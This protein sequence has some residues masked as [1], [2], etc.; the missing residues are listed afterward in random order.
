M[1]RKAIAVVVLAAC[2]L[3][4]KAQFTSVNAQIVDSDGTQWANGTYTITFKGSVPG[5]PSINGIFFTQTFSGTLSATGQFSAT[6]ADVAYVYPPNSTWVFTVKAAT[7]S[8][9]IY[10]ISIP[11]TG[12][13]E[14]VSTQI[15]AA[16]KPPRLTGGQLSQAYND[17]EVTAVPGNIYFR[18][19]DGSF[20]CYTT[21]WVACGGISAITGTGTANTI[22]MWTGTTVL[23]N[24]PLSVISGVLTSSDPMAIISSSAPTQTD[25]TPSG[26][27]NTTTAGAASL[28]APT[29]VVTAGVYQLPSAPGSGAYTGTNAAGIVATTFT[30]FQGTDANLLTSGTFTGATGAAVCKD[31]NGGVTTVGCAAGGVTSLNS[32]SGVLSLTSTGATVTITP[33]GSTINLEVAAS[34]GF[35][36][37]IGSTSIAASS[38]TT[39]IAG[40]TLTSPTFTTPALGTPA[41]GVITNLTGTCA[42]CVAN[43]AGS[44]SNALTMNNSGTGAASGST[45]N[46]ASAQT[47][48]YNT[49]G[50]APLASPTFTGTV[51]VPS[52]SGLGTPTTLVLT[53]ATGLP[54]AT[55]ISGLGTGVATALAATPS[56]TGSIV[57]ATSPTLVTPNLGTPSALVLTS[58]TGLPW[59]SLVAP[60]AALSF[61]MPAG[62]TTSLTWAANAAPSSPNWTWTSGADTG[63]STAAAFSF[64]DTT[65]STKTGSL[66]NINTVG[67]STALPLQ[68]TAQGT[69]NG[70]SMTSAGLLKPIGTGGIQ[71]STVN[72]NT[73]PASAGLTSG[74]V[75]CATSTSAVSTSALLTSNAFI[76]GGG[77]GVCPAVGLA[78]D[79][80]TSFTY[81]GTQGIISNPTTVAGSFVMRQ[82]TT[83]STSTTSVSH[84]VPT[85]VTSY[86][87]VE[88]GA[89]SAN[90]S[91][92]KSY[93][94]TSGTVTTES[95]V[96]APRKSML[97]SAYTNATATASTITSFTVD[98]S[99]SY[100][101]DCKGLY[102][103]ATGGAF[104]FT[105]T[106]PASPTLVT[107][108]FRPATALVSNAPTFLDYA[109]TGSTYPSA[110]NTTAVTT[111]ATDMPYELTIGFTNGTTAGTV[112]IQG[113]TIS[114]NTLTVEAG[115]YCIAY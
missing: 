81:T 82:G 106:G 78:A 111:A 28:A 13:S 72:G 41:S 48:S 62:D 4:A 47:L 45:F 26:F 77:A 31:A 66:V 63:T 68:V 90:N 33:S 64:L 94:A 108:N 52:G 69:A 93:A 18:L 21:G 70:I 86:I 36:I 101:I 114:T 40:L 79:N 102:K 29:T 35:P 43:S 97:T 57:L 83:I 6:L 14:N 74:G 54:V 9:Q 56:G 8:A 113:A 11:V 58:A 20:R 2:S 19:S 7:T 103:A 107:Y 95:F 44:V 71:A 37:T 67:T 34:S 38:T 42:S 109:A 87:V 16:I 96:Q 27:A 24:A 105:M 59:S 100:T 84:T 110:V 15:N 51:T 89:I 112:A 3:V 98:A 75:L 104:T 61:T 22:A 12:L 53:N 5:Q 50:A 55:G 23:G 1:I 10:T 60:T 32:L 25:Y 65:G 85:A 73:F 80:G 92:M 76:K 39:S 99:T 17:G 91:V 49:L 46:G 88:P 30:P 115:S